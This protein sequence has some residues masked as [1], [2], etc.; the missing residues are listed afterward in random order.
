MKNNVLDNIL[1]GIKVRFY[2]EIIHLISNV[3]NL[4]KLEI[5]KKSYIKYFKC[6]LI[7]H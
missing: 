6:I 5:K 4:L 3:G 1:N 2:Q 7:I